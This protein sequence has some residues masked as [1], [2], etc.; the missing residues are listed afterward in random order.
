MMAVQDHEW[1]VVLPLL[2][3]STVVGEMVEVMVEDQVMAGYD[4]QTQV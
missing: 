4:N 1:R 3:S 2:L